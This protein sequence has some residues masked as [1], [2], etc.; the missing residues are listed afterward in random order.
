MTKFK[1][2]DKVRRIKNF[3]HWGKL[4]Y[5]S[6]DIVTITNTV[7]NSDYW[8]K[9]E[10]HYLCSVNFELVESVEEKPE[11]WQVGWKV[12][13]ENRKAQHV[14]IDVTDEYYVLYCVNGLQPS[15][16]LSRHN[17]PVTAKYK[18]LD[19]GNNI[20]GLK[21]PNVIQ[22]E[23][24]MIDLPCVKN[25]PPVPA[26][27][28]IVEGPLFN[29]SSTKIEGQ[30]SKESKL[31]FISGEAGIWYDVEYLRKTAQAMNVLANIIEENSTSNNEIK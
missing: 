12:Q 27:R 24:V 3:E 1:V 31:V 6:N 8:I 29:G 20:I 28:V 17:L 10:G 11:V 30:Y 9:V 7:Y 26:S 16:K 19:R 18:V 25:I 13:N 23:N 22:K 2:G 5:K 4:G 14:V 21:L 15:W